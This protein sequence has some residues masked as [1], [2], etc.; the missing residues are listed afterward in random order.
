[1]QPIYLQ[2]GGKKDM[3]SE[4]DYVWRKTKKIKQQLQMGQTKKKPPCS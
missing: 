4:V 1:V 2:G 3:S